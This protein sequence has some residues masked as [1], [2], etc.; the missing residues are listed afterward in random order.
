MADLTSKASVLTEYIWKQVLEPNRQLL[1]IRAVYYGDQDTLPT[2]PIVCVI[3]ATKRKDWANTGHK[4]DNVFEMSL[5]VYSTGL[6]DTGSIQHEC[7]VLTEGV[8]DL[9]D[10]KSTPTSQGLGGDQLGGLI[11]QGLCV[12]IEYGYKRFNDKLARMN[13]IIYRASSR[14]T[15]L[16]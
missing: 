14:S 6:N 4:V 2:S 7:D 5:L 15:F 3:P 11:T 9:L 12:G 10:L 16:G 8:E 1:G 13:R